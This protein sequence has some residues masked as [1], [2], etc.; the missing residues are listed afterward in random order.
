[1]HSRSCC[2]ERAARVPIIHR[3]SLT[4]LGWLIDFIHLRLRLALWPDYPS[5]VHFLRSGSPQLLP[6]LAKKRSHAFASHEPRAAAQLDAE[7]LD[8]MSG[9]RRVRINVFSW[10]DMNGLGRKCHPSLRTS[11]P[12]VKPDM[13][14]TLIAGRATVI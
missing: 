5:F 3:T 13:S 14:N 9:V 11:I 2:S 7:N 6:L 1:M 4:L 10:D 8:F 12:P